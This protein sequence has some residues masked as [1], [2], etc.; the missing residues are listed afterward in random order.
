MT[1]AERDATVGHVADMVKLM[2]DDEPHNR[3]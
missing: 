1:K 3:R 2:F